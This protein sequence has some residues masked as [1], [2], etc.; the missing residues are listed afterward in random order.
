MK[1]LTVRGVSD[2][3][4]RAL[5]QEAERRGTS[6]NRVVLAVLK[7]AMGVSN[8]NGRHQHMFDDLDRLAGAWSRKEAEIFEESLNQQRAIDETMWQ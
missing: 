2:D 6:M 3:L 4:H 5:K 1:R 7:E 8:D